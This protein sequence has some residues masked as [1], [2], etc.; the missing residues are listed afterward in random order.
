M[1]TILIRNGKV[2]TENEAKIKDILVVDDKIKK[3]DN[4]IDFSASEI[5][6]A[7]GKIVIPGG[8]DVH[9]HLNLHAGGYI[10][11]DD[12]YIGT[13]AAA[14]GG[15]TTIV[16]HPGFG[17][18]GCSLGH[19]ID[20]YH[21][22]AKDS[23]VIDYSFHGILQHVDNSILDEIPELINAGI[24]SFKA[25]L[26]HDYPLNDTDIL[27]LM[28]KLKEHGGVLAVYC[29]NDHIL[30]FY[31][32]KYL[33][34][35]N[36]APIYHAKSRVDICE[37][38]AVNRMIC[39]SRIAGNAPLYLLHV[40]SKASID[41]IK[42]AHMNE[43]C[44]I[45][46][47]CPQYLLL[48]EDLYNNDDGMKYISTPPLRKSS[49]QV[50]L[51]NGINREYIST[52]ATD[53][54]SYSY[55]FRKKVAQNSFLKCPSGLP[56]IETRIPLMFSEGVM[57][58]KISLNRFVEINCTNPAKVMGLYPQKGVLKEGSD[59]D[60]VIIDP[61]KEVVLTNDL[62]HQNI[63]YTPYDGFKLE[64]YPVLTMSRGKVI[65]K[66]NEFIGEKGSGKFIKRKSG[67]FV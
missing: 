57:Q 41:Y 14:C 52:V 44:V 32:E 33:S 35:G 10:A 12:F 26:T 17:P 9:T 11:D 60:I 55:K 67:V 30:Q 24:S 25:Y 1:N 28:L 65:V 19:Q 47:T 42:L 51:W 48:D 21:E 58:Y 6:D 45:A 15:T 16:D 3:I 23:S 8:V 38:E 50:A 36:E 46:E 34:E 66:D 22:Y 63:D 39:L 31:R 2:V 40:S 7:S 20:K 53:H 13:V 64:G 43:G 5:I 37:A 54:C 62:L 56:G 4:D 29:E 27:K 59:A 49:D 18:K 61:D